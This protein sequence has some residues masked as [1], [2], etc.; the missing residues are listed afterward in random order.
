[1][2]VAVLCCW[3]LCSGWAGSVD[4]R[5]WA[6]PAVVGLT[7]PLAV[8]VA[9]TAL[10]VTLLA[11]AWKALAALALALLL[12][13]PAL[14]VNVPMHVASSA[15]SDSIDTFTILTF[16]V[17]GFSS[18]T[19]DEEINVTMRYILDVNADVVMLQET[20]MG[21][22]DYF[23]K[24]NM[25]P[26][27]REI[28]AKYPYHSRGYHDVAILSRYPYTV[29]EDST[30]R[31]G[32]GAP[33]NIHTEYHAY[34]KVFDI[35]MPRGRQ[36]R[37]I[38]TH[39]QSIGLSDSDKQAYHN[40]THLDSVS[41]GRQINQVRHSLYKKLAGAFY[42]RAGESQQLRSAIDGYDGNVVVCG[43]FNDT[44]ASYCYW[45]VRGDDL[46]D[47]YA[48]CGCG[49]TYT[50]NSNLMLFKIDHVLYKGAMRAIDIRRDKAG[51]SDHYPLLTTFEW[52]PA[53]NVE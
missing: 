52:L 3:V 22:K 48:Q 51:A 47:A 8:I 38:G 23:Y 1:M 35:D 29:R 20:S 25:Q 53:A 13:W 18:D 6:L 36:V 30:L 24:P 16:N 19:D 45:T 26:L 4:P 11:K 5:R 49:M 28:E 39:M 37:V 21:P 42:R 7:Y 50:F 44:P 14:R 17:R 31:N 2:A 15:A 27:L 9:L 33:D 43:D 41:D 32:I 10:L 34:A 12:T 40:L 46:A